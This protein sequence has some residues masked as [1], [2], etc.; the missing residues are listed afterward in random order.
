MTTA[1]RVIE[2]Q[3]HEESA[4][5]ELSLEEY[6][7][8][9]ETLTNSSITRIPGTENEYKVNP[10]NAV[11][12][13]RIDNLVIDIKPKIPFERVLFL[14]AYALKPDYW[15]HQIV[16]LGNANSSS[17]PRVIS[18]TSSPHDGENCYL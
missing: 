9:S 14:V 10:R 2:L 12:I 8:L 18:E 11:G 5:I 16:Q 3:E 1:E 13:L 6:D 4:A 17:T 15:Q 7:L